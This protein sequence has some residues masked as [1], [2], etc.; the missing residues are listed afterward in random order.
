[1]SPRTQNRIG[2]V[3]LLV[4]A[5]GAFYLWGPTNEIDNLLGLHRQSMID[6]SLEWG[7]L[8]PFP[9]EIT[10][11]T[12]R[13]QG[14]MF[15]RTFIGSFTTSPDIIESWLGQSVGVRDGKTEKLEDGSTK[16]LLK[17]GSGA[18]YGEVIVSPDRKQVSFKIA[19]S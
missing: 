11:F 4:L 19:W 2:F 8:A 17:P 10:D 12:I 13:T 18:A 3:I 7:Q 6:C 14:S 1:M 5:M 16:Y 15:T 9:K